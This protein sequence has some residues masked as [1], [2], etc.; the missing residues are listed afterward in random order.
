MGAIKIEDVIQV[1]EAT[2]GSDGRVYVGK[3]H[4]DRDVK[5]VVLEP[6]TKTVDPD[7]D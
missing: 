3:H 2:V 7:T 6:G 4:A 5:L 1:K